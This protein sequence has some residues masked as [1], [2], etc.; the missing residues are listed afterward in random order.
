MAEITGI[1]VPRPTLL[2][3]NRQVVHSRGDFVNRDR[4]NLI[5]ALERCVAALC[6]YGQ[7]LWNDVNAMRTSLIRDQPPSGWEGQP[8]GQPGG[9]LGGDVRSVTTA[10]GDAVGAADD[11]DGPVAWNASITAYAA[12]TSVPTGPH[13]DLMLLAS[14]CTRRA[15]SPGCDR[16]RAVDRFRHGR[17][18]MAKAREAVGM[19]ETGSG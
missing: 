16:G 17:R 18:A 3:P 15:D 4:Q 11:A 12:V 13:D 9:D 5:P 8:I 2:N 6:A 1:R 14:R 19:P 7:Q 10:S